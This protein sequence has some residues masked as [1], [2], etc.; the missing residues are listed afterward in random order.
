MF[1]WQGVE[2]FVL[3]ADA[4]DRVP[5]LR[6]KSYSDFQLMKRDWDKLEVIRAVLRVQWTRQLEFLLHLFTCCFQKPADAQQSFS[7][8][9]HPTVWRIIPT[10][11]FLMKRWGTMC[12]ALRHILV[13]CAHLY[14][15]STRFVH[16]GPSISITGLSRILPLSRYL[17]AVVPLT[18]F[19]LTFLF[20]LAFPRLC[21]LPCWSHL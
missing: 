10:I 1:C 4:S 7:S 2:Q 20:S 21:C 3:L 17:A 9:R 14:L 19:V 12:Y 6:N 8:T 16:T 13:S 11:E 5:T 18:S 15:Y